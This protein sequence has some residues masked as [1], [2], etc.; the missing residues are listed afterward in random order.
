MLEKVNVLPITLI[1]NNFLFFTF[2]IQLRM[3][4]IIDKY[5]YYDKVCPTNR[6]Y[7]YEK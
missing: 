3:I 1:F 4:V 2:I 7:V 6:G 5:N